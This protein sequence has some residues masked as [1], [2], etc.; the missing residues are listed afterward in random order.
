MPFNKKHLG[1]LMRKFISASYKADLYKS[2]KEELQQQIIESIKLLGEE[3]PV[4]SV[5]KCKF[6]KIYID[7]YEGLVMKDDA[8]DI[9]LQN[10]DVE[11]YRKCIIHLVDIDKLREVG[12]DDTIIQKLYN[13]KSYEVL[14]YEV[15][16]EKA[17]NT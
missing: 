16:K 6:I 3:E 2:R 1:L 15:V 17:P 14:R 11:T 9:L 5:P 7:K 10:I 4:V 8:A 13:I 12:I